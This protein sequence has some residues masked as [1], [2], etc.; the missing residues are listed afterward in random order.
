MLALRGQRVAG[1]GLGDFAGAQK[2]L[3]SQVVAV[4]SAGDTYYAAD[5]SAFRLDYSDAVSSY[6][7][8]GQAGASS[9]GPEIDAAGQAAL[10]QPLT[11]QA[12]ALNA[13]LAALT[14]SG[15]A[16][17]KNGVT[18]AYFSKG[19]ADQAKQLAKQIAALYT[20]A[21]TAGQAA[22]TGANNVAPVQPPPDATT[23]TA[24]SSSSGVIFATALVAGV[25]GAVAW[26]HARKGRR[27]A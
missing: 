5:A 18:A 9:V 23:T 11:Q 25:A 16:D 14:K 13:T 19:D 27:H 8:A 6:Q 1:F 21:I 20:Q 4:I 22:Q 3:A 17:P 2:D 10:T 26:S 15:A 12:W 7:A 24:S